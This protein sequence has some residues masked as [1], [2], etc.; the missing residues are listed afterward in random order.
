V[1]DVAGADARGLAGSD[2]AFVL[3]L[4]GTGDVLESDIQLVRMP[5]GGA[6]ELF[7]S[8][9]D[10]GGS[11][12][13][14]EILVDRSVRLASVDVPK[15]APTPASATV[16]P[17]V[18]VPASGGGAAAAA[19]GAAAPDR[20]YAFLREL[21]ITRGRPGLRAHLRFAKGASLRAVSVKVARDGVTIARGR[22]KPHGRRGLLGLELRHKLPHGRYDVTVTAVDRAG[23]R[24]TVRR[25]VRIR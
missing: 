25:S 17:A 2:E 1:T 4:S 6:T 19:K 11:R 10:A 21:S 12:Q 18:V 15:P 14:Y 3:R 16:A 24:T 9:V 7:V 20:R 5:G 23:V 8:P 22:F 13:A